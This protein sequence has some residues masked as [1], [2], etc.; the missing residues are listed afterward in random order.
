MSITINGSGTLAGVSVG[1]LPDGSV[2]ADTLATDAVTTVKIEDDAVT[3]A[4]QNL[5]GAAKVW[6]FYSNTGAI[7]KSFNVSSVTDNSTGKHT[8]NFTNAV[9]DSNYVVVIGLE[10]NLTQTPWV[11]SKTT[12]S[13][14]CN[15]YQDSGFT[16]QTVHMALFCP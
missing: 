7:Q 6:C 9:S 14:R 11:S 13:A 15:T 4:K 8:V 10:N 16:D 1:G 3:D 12:T 2:D 5:N